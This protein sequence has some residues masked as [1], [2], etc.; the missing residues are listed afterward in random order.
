[1]GIKRS[2]TMMLFI[3]AGYIS[4]PNSFRLHCTHAVMVIVC[5]HQCLHS[6]NWTIKPMRA[7]Y[8]LFCYLIKHKYV[9]L[10]R[11]MPH[12]IRYSYRVSSAAI[13]LVL[14]GPKLYDTH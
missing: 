8:V 2:Q 14:K 4:Q 13:Y 1:M 3:P 5:I 9:N 12:N 11:A 6:V 7:N 10:P